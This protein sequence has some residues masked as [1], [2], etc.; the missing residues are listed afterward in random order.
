MA[1]GAWIVTKHHRHCNA[2]NVHV[3]LAVTMAKVTGSR[4]AVH[5]DNYSHGATAKYETLEERRKALNL[6]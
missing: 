5:Q 6:A 1:N 4:E 2:C 3:D